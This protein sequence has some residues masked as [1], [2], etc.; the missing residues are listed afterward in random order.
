MEPHPDAKT[1][2]QEA[3][4]F[5]NNIMKKRAITFILSDFIS[6]PYYD[7]LN[8]AGKRHDI[9]G[10]HVYDQ[11]DKE[12]PDLGVIKMQD[13]ES[14]KQ[15]WVDTSSA[16]FQKMYTAKYIDQEKT[17]NEAFVKRF[18]LCNYSNG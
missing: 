14:G 1:N 5:L 11:R 16:T 15:V 7:A 2:I 13:S 3:L 8:V 12:I 4:K 6:A 17:T 10:I 9:I 18:I